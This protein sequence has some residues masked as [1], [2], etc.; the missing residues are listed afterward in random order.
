MSYMMHGP[1]MGG[2]HQFDVHVFTN[3]PAN[4]E[5]VLVARSN[6]VE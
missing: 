6:W 4:E 5:M 2:Q 3:D 1:A